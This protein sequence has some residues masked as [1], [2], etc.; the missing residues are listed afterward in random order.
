M[1]EEIKPEWIWNN[2]KYTKFCDFI[3]AYRQSRPWYINLYW[4]IRLKYLSYKYRLQDYFR[5]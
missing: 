1:K 4:S 5:K 2:E 3:K